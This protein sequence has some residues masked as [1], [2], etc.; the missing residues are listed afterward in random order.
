V[1]TDA[2]RVDYSAPVR[3][4]I[5][6][7]LG[8]FL[9]VN[10][11]GAFFEPNIVVERDLVVAGVDLDDG[12]D[13]ARLFRLVGDFAAWGEWAPIM[14]AVDADNGEVRLGEPSTGEGGSVTVVFDA[15]YAILLMFA[16]CDPATGVTVEARMG[17]VDDD[18]EA[19]D[20]FRAWDRIT[21]EPAPEGG[22]R[23]AWKRTGQEL[24]LYLLRLWD[25]LVVAPS[26]ADQLE[27]GLE[28]LAVALS[29]DAPAADDGTSSTSESS[30]SDGSVES[31]DSTDASR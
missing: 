30:P 5:I 16:R 28:R 26:V 23:L 17:T 4:V 15:S 20:G 18:L 27:E 12:E 8:L 21:W 3:I 1:R 24:P 22:V 31:T 2:R 25:H 19:G 10:V 7:V 6:T 29:S 13:A 11:I 14:G 9:L